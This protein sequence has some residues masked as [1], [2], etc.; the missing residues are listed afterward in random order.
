MRILVVTQYFWPENF[1]INDLCA[2][3]VL[4]GHD[5]TILTGKPNY[6][7]GVVFGAY[8]NKPS[9]FCQYQGC[10]VIRV[11]MIARGENAIHLILN[12]LSFALTASL[13]GAFKLRKR[14]YDI[15]FVYEPSPITVGLPAI[16]LKILKKAPVVFWVLDLWP[17][18]LEAVGV[19]K[20][21]KVLM[22]IGKLV[23]FIYNRC[24]LILGQSKSFINS[25]ENYCDDKEKIRYFPSWAEDLFLSESV[26][27]IND[28]AIFE[29]NFKVLFAGNIGESQDFPAIVKAVE[30]LKTKKSNVK[31][32]IVGD[33]RA[34]SWL[35]S[36]IK[37]KNLE[38]YIYL[39]GRHPLEMMASFYASA[40][41]LLVSLKE[42]KVFAMTIPGKVQSYMAAG[43]P[44]LSMVDGEGNRVIEEAKCGYT[45]KSGDYESLANS[46]MRMSRLAQENLEPLGINAKEYSLKEFDRDKL[47]SQLEV[48]FLDI[49]ENKKK[50]LIV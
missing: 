34:F 36:Q 1:R 41:A 9:E 35:K 5:V 8:K 4:R 47:I 15:I 14:K 45:S 12:Y 3:L 18:T 31:L 39:L 43:K 23:S 7:D 33:G 29:D 38:N 10:E 19:V 2:E 46:M 6:P 32:F 22:I 30:I 27:T 40:D 50:E 17:E 28:V 16:Y 11:P 37:E 20:S 48:W 44:I 42:N 25:I 49:M 26:P 13:N 24:D 21:P